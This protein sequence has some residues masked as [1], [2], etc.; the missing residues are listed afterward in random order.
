MSAVIRYAG[1]YEATLASCG[2]PIVKTR[3][4]SVRGA[5]AALRCV[6]GGPLYRV[7]GGDDG[8]YV[9]ASLSVARRDADGSRA[10]AVIEVQS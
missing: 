2:E 6:A 3:Y 8:I 5:L 9:Y 1:C 4:R 10:L 7:I